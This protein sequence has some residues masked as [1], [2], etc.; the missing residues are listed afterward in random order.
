MIGEVVAKPSSGMTKKRARLTTNRAAAAYAA[1]V[2][3]VELARVDIFVSSE[4]SEWQL[5][6][7]LFTTARLRLFASH[8]RLSQ[9]W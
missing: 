9:P 5:A 1:Q 8:D 6:W 7:W 2:A 4:S 3:C